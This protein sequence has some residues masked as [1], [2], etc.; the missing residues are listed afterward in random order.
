MLDFPRVYDDRNLEGQFPFITIPM[1]IVETVVS[2]LDTAVAGAKD[3]AAGEVYNLQDPIQDGNIS[4][5]GTAA[6]LPSGEIVLTGGGGVTE[7]LAEAESMVPD[8]VDLLLIAASGGAPGLGA[9]AASLGAN[10][11]LKAAGFDTPGNLMGDMRKIALVG[12]VW[13]VMKIGV[14]GGPNPLDNVRGE[15]EEA[16]ESVDIPSANSLETNIPS[17]PVPNTSVRN[18]IG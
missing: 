3:A 15:V 1:S 17:V 14:L 8:E 5:I 2:S 10:V 4:G 9:V 11:A 13:E 12:T 18:V 6:T 16:T 7:S